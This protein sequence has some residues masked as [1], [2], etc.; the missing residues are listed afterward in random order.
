MKRRRMDPRRRAAKSA[1]WDRQKRRATR[2]P[3]QINWDDIPDHD[4]E[5]IAVEPSRAADAARALEDA[6]LRF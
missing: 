2:G 4:A 1:E 5:I 3:R 6:G